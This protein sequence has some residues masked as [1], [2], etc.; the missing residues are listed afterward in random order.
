[1]VPAAA[2]GH[3][4]CGWD[5]KPFGVVWMCMLVSR[6]ELQADAGH[7]RAAKMDSVLEEP[8]LKPPTETLESDPP[9]V[10]LRP[11]MTVGRGDGPAGNQVTSPFWVAGPSPHPR[12]HRRDTQGSFIMGF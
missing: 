8:S 2:E 10:R 4:A 12:F 1:M 7:R 5:E 3:M 11:W 6:G 9:V